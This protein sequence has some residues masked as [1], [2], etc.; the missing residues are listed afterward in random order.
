MSGGGEYSFPDAGLHA[1]TYGLAGSDIA[2][3]DLVRPGGGRVAA[4]MGPS[5]E[6]GYRAWLIERTPG[7]LDGIEGLDAAGNVVAS[8]GP[9]SGGD[10]FTYSTATC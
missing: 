4:R 3:V 8:I 5:V 2:R 7:N 10:D 9:L 6:A 1:F